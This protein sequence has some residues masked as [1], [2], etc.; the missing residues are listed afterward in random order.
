MPIPIPNEGE[1]QKIFIGRCNSILNEEFP[2]SKQRN[3]V[4]FSQWRKSKKDSSEINDSVD[5]NI[6]FNIDSQ[7]N[8]KLDK[9]TGFLYGKAHVTRAGV[10]DYYDEAGNLMRE[11][12]SPQ[13]VFNNES[14]DSLKLKP[15]V[16]D[17]P[18][19]MV[20][21]DNI[22]DL[23][24]GMVGDSIEKD[25]MFLLSNIVITDKNIIKNILDRKKAGLSTEL[26]CGYSCMLIPEIGN[27]TNDG[28]YTF[29]QKNIRYN[30]VGI[31]DRGR[32]G[33]EVKILDKHNKQKEFNKM[34][35]K[36]QFSRKAIN[37][38]SFK[39]D[40]ITEIMDEES[41]KIVNT[42]SNKLDEA[43]DIIISINKDK[44]IL[45]GKLDQ[46]NETIKSLNEKNDSLSDINS[47]IVSNLVDSKIRL[48]KIAESLKV[49]CINK[50]AKTIKIDCIKAI[51]KDF[52][53]TNKSDDYLNSR[54]DSIEE[55][56]KN[57]DKEE[58]KENYKIFMSNVDKITQNNKPI[59]YRTE[60]IKK[61]TE[62]NR[63]K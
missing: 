39:I 56:I 52:D 3:A 61:D 18:D 21:V 32:A 53:P 6:Y 29:V 37:L 23:A 54:I 28:Y 22:K 19:S 57:K 31:V 2:D 51:S 17:H 44:D 43:S 45:Q 14:M 34:G 4:C 38:D 59:D 55:L 58:N 46:A 47:P 20:N 48:Y 26:S 7:T 33:R 1:E 12:R 62:K 35:N 15:I 10:F 49:D 36:I 42:L 11:Y 63:N 50:D 5:R 8:L 13:E 16:Y 41:I 60:F 25:N 40:A 9:E 24:V 27:D 30:H